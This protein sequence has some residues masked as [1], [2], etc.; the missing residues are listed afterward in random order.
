M[1]L[2]IP[3]FIQRLH[4]QDEFDVGH[5]LSSSTLDIKA[6]V[7]LR[8]ESRDRNGGAAASRGVGGRPTKSKRVM[9]AARGSGGSSLVH[10]TSNRSVPPTHQV[11]A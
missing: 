6:R 11:S 10:S 1:K 3:S 9:G 5:L 8:V 2:G 7:A 4:S